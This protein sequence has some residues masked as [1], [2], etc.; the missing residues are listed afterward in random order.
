MDRISAAGNLTIEVSPERWCLLINGNGQEQV[1]VEVLPGEPLHYRP[2]FA[3]KRRLPDTGKLPGDQIQRVVL[4]WSQQDETWHLGLLLEPAMAEL[5]G[6]RWCEMAR[7][8]DPDTN[9]F[10]ETADQAGRSLASALG[11]PYNFIAPEPKTETAAAPPPPLP[12]LPLELDQWTLEKADQL[13][14]RRSPRWARA[15][16]LRLVWYGL[17]VVVYVI[18][19]L[20]TLQGKIALPKPEFLPYLG[21]AVAVLLVGAIVYTLF[22][23]GTVPNRIQIDAAARTISGWRGDSQKWQLAPEDYQ[24]IYV[25]QVV[26]KKGKKS[27]AQYGEL[28]VLLVS[29]KFRHLVSVGE[30]KELRP[31]EANDD[32]LIELAQEAV[33]TDLQAAGLYVAQ[34]LGLICW[35]DRRSR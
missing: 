10:S 31:G 20:L 28:N 13:Q 3:Q 32:L 17:L 8:P 30:E 11:R 29:G 7:W 19:S 34:A 14:L 23:L 25:S 4:G 22:Q 33:Q 18:L 16:L 5:R 2:A 26:G 27:L 9:V 12:V 6:S 35:Y 15:H 21:L 24:S 1:L